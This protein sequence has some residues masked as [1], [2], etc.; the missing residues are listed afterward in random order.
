[1]TIEPKVFFTSDLHFGHVGV[2]EFCNRPFANIDEMDHALIQNWNARVTKHDRIYVLGDLSLGIKIGRLVEIL[3]QLSGQKF[4]VAGNHDSKLRD[5]QPLKDQFIWVKDLASVKVA[6]TEAK[7]KHPMAASKRKQHIVLCHYPFA[8]WN[9]MAH[10]SWHLHGHSH[11]GLSHNP[12]MPA[13][14]RIDVGVDSVGVYSA[15]EYA[16][17]EYQE[18]KVVIKE[19]TKNM[20]EIADEGYV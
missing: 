3:K 10:G 1:M 20:L 8:T 19:R 5:K 15:I 17:I 16:P 11:G 2:I 7:T 12:L 13:P 14:N 4:L 9:R 18:L 6:D